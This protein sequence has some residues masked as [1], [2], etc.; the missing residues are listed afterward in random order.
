MEHYCR[1]ETFPQTV[2]LGIKLHAKDLGGHLN[3]PK[4]TTNYTLRSRIAKGSEVWGW[5]ARS[6][7]P[8]PQKLRVLTTV[9][10]PRCLHGIGAIQLG[11]ER[12]DKLRS[13]AMNALGWQKHGPHQSCSL[14]FAFRL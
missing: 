12:L 4:R 8:I 2:R 5:L 14:G 3:Y 10:W 1:G 6:N 7:A 11:H 9:V 13:D